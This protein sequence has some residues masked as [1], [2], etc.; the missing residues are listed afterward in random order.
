MTTLPDIADSKGLSAAPYL[1]GSIF[2]EGAGSKGAKPRPFNYHLAVRNFHHWGYAACTLNANAVAGVPLRMYTRRG[3]R[4]GRMRK[5]YDTRPV[6][7]ATCRYLSGRSAVKPSPA[8][9]A[10]VV[11][12]GDDIEEV[13]APHPLMQVLNGPNGDDNGYEMTVD[14]II[15]YQNA[16]NSYWYVVENGLDVPAQLFRLPPQWTQVKPNEKRTGDRRVAGYV[17]GKNTANEVEFT[18]DEVDHFRMPNPKEGGLFYGMGWVEAAWQSLGLHNAKRTEDLAMKDNFSRPD[19]LLSI[20]NGADTKAITRLQTALE[21]RFR[22]PANAGKPMLAT[23]EIT[24]TALQWE[25]TELGTPTRLIEEIAAISGVPV[26]MLMT[27]DQN[28]AGGEGA[29][30]QWYRTTVRSYC[31]RDEQKLNQRYVT[32]W[33]GHEDFIVAYDHT[34]FEDRE[35]V[36]KEVVALT[37]GGVISPNEARQELG[38]HDAEGADLLY[39]PAGNTGGSASV[40]GNLSPQQNDERRDRKGQKAVARM[41]KPN[42]DAQALAF[43]QQAFL[44]FQKDG[45][46]GDILANLTDLG[47]LVEDVGLSRNEDYEEPYVPV[48][49]A[50]GPVVDGTVLRD[51]EQDI[52]GGGPGIPPVET[53]QVN[54]DGG[55]GDTANGPDLAQD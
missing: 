29:R 5:Q 15:D 28:R 33:E 52:V 49:S 40:M 41:P 14:R 11:A 31:L 36:T 39:P 21:E 25:Q 27:N 42:T 34:S 50:I 12:W 9:A 37:S 45:T 48:V 46:V 18:V 3:G 6:G 44:G 30:L 26:S 23:G 47:D 1:A 17:F 10:K 22:G 35:A 20:K 32:R 19:W 51:D 13:V 55:G 7:R 8:V 43:K 4:T 16:G 53:V 2:M 54:K 24:A 38:Y